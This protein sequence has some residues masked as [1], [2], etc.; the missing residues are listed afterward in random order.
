[1]FLP[2]RDDN[3][4]RRLPWVTYSLIAANLAVHLWQIQALNQGAFW[5][6]AWYGLVPS[7]LFSDP[8][9]EVVTVGSSMFL[10]A[11]WLHLAS[12]MWFLHIFGDNLEDGL[13]HWRYL[14]FYLLCGLAAA[15]LQ[16]L[17]NPSSQ[18]PMVGASGAIAG[19]V[20]AYMLIHPRAPI[21]SLNTVPLLWLFMGIFVVVPAWVIA[22]LF[23]LQNLL[24]AY[25]SLGNLGAAGVAF[26]AHLGG[27]VAG[28]ML[29]KPLLGRKKIE[30]RV[31]PGFAK[32][33]RR[34]RRGP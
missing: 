7:R 15:V 23:F 18:V 22:L 1:M 12:N 9:G 28:V 8:A 14:L 13:G 26:F 21:F 2:L 5:L 30:R 3:P 4:T 32:P 27:F 31:W 33:E 34:W 16:A 10:H 6:P 17:V 24:M 11:G 25:Q 29:I 20:G 19:V